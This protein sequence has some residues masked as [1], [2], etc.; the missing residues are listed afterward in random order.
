MQHPVGNARQPLQT[1]GFI[2]LAQQGRDASLT[3]NPAPFRRRSQ[4]QQPDR[5]QASCSAQAHITT[6]H[7]QNTFTPKTRRQGTERGLV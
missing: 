2:Q 7:N 3:Q 6:P 1:F 5:G 4:G